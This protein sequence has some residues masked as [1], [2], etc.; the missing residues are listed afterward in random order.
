MFEL[1]FYFFIRFFF[2][3]FFTIQKLVQEKKSLLKKLDLSIVKEF[4]DKIL[5]QQNFFEA[6]KVPGFF[7]TK[8]AQQ[9][10]KQSALLQIALAN[11]K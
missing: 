5:Q 8:D 10:A 11:I 3:H 7:R 9:V 6:L 2:F 1:L 4:E